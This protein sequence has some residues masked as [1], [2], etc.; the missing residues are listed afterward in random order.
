MLAPR[1]NLVPRCWSGRLQR[2]WLHE[3]GSSVT[4][5]RFRAGW[6]GKHQ[7]CPRPHPVGPGAGQERPSL[8]LG[9]FC[10]LC[11]SVP[12]MLSSSVARCSSQ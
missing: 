6:G 11:A 10:L 9:G 2:N 1:K 7:P 12:A 3:V 5:A 4:A 8:V